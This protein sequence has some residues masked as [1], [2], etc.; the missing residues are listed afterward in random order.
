[1]NYKIFGRRTGLRV[2][3]LVLGAGN[4]GTGWGHGADAAESRK[5]F[6]RYVE[7][8][9]N[10]IDTA[11]DYQS[12]QSEK[13]LSELIAPERD[14][15]VVATKYTFGA[16][17]S[18]GLLTTG[19]SRKNMIR[20]VEAS[21]KRL[22]TDRLD[23]LWAHIS[24]GQTPID[25]I[26]RGFDDLVRAG[27]ILYPVFSNFPAWRIA[28]AIQIADLRGWAPIAG[29]QVEYNLVARSAERE[30]LP[31]A[32]ALGLGV[33][34]WS[35]LAGGLLTGK[36]RTLKDTTD[37]RLNKLSY[38]VRTEEERSTAILDK[39]DEIAKATGNR[40]MDIA[41]AWV[42]QHH[43][44]TQLSDVTIIGPRTL[45][46]LE[47]NLDSLKVTLSEEHI[48]Q[49]NDVSDFTPDAIHNVIRMVVGRIHGAG[50]EVLQKHPV[51]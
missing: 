14:N 7:A 3:E 10:T 16:D 1:M 26:V 31:M 25:E 13:I 42:R 34:Y 39:L 8:G 38:L 24:D 36:Y 19:N 51:A 30:L 49:L 5:I 37:T 43:A 11:D 6:D 46:Q 45:S 33:A 17:P 28:S 27:K 4:F 22:K 44:N 15:L 48:R 23:I 20:S 21:L 2:S 18:H 47:D 9:G 50:S 40:M 32:E 12:G 41:L 35:P 29:I